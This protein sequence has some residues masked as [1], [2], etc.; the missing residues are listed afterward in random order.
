MN[1]KLF[2]KFWLMIDKS[3]V[4]LDTA[5]SVFESWEEDG[6]VFS[7]MRHAMSGKPHGI[8]RQVWPDEGVYEGCYKNGQAH[9]LERCI[10]ANEIRI[11]LHKNGK[12]LAF[13]TFN[14]DFQMIHRKGNDLNDLTAN[15][16]KPHDLQ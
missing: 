1:V 6:V 10:S 2:L 11:G 8:I 9:G 14:R 15:Y 12:E 16:F 5:E 3:A 7:G 13:F 4:L